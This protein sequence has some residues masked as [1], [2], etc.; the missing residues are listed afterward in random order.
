LFTQ[1][2]FP[3]GG[4]DLGLKVGELIKAGFEL[5]SSKYPDIHGKWVATSY[6]IGGQLPNSSLVSSVQRAGEMDVL[7]RCMEDELRI[8]T[9]NQ[10]TDF[11]FHYQVMLSELWVG[12][13]Y[14]IIRLLKDRMRMPDNKEFDL[15]AHH[16][17]LLRIPIE[18]HEIPGDKKLKAPLMMKRYP[19][20]DEASDIYEYS[21]DDP[22]RSHIMPT[23]VS[24]R[25][26]VVWQV[27]DIP[28]NESF[29]IER[30]DLSE[31]I[32]AIIGDAGK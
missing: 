8:H 18:K 15:L 22:T 17:R 26:S 12:H 19:P 24:E 11:S 21:K 3:A 1:E 27:L 6:R 7:L 30:R 13:M 20:K 32:L 2:R 4:K 25:G 10:E 31:R 29:W 14:E 28:S 16:L 9:D 23:G 5:A